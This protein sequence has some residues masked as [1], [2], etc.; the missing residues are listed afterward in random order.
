MGK[1]VVIEIQNSDFEQG[2]QVI[3][4]IGECG[5]NLGDAEG[6]LPDNPELFNLY[7]EWQKSYKSHQ[8]NFERHKLE[9]INKK[10][11][12]IS[13]FDVN[14]KSDK[15][16]QQL[17]QWLDSPDFGVIEKLFKQKLNESEQILVIVRTDKTELQ[18][19][20]W[21][22]WY[23][24]E[25]YTNADVALCP[26]VNNSSTRQWKLSNHPDKIR[27]LAAFGQETENALKI[28]T[29]TNYELLKKCLCDVKKTIDIV[30]IF[31]SDTENLGFRLREEKA[32]IF[33]YAGH[34][35]SKKN[36]KGGEIDGKNIRNLTK[37]FKEAVDKGLKLAIF[38]SCEGLGIANQLLKESHIPHV[39]VMREPIQDKVAHTFLKYFIQ[40][41]TE[42]DP[43]HLALKKARERLHDL[44]EEH[45][46]ASW[47]PVIF[48][49]STE[50]PSNWYNFQTTWIKHYLG[51]I[52]IGA[53]GLIIL[54]GMMGVMALRKQAPLDQIAKNNTVSING[55][56]Q[57]SAVIFAK[58]GKTYYVL[59]AKSIVNPKDKYKIV[60][61]DGN[62]H[63]AAIDTKINKKISGIDL[64]ILQFDSD[65]SYSI[66]RLGNSDTAR[67]GTAVFLS[68]W[69]EIDGSGEQS[70]H[71]IEGEIASRPKT[72]LN[73]YSLIYGSNSREGM[74]GGPLIDTH[75]CVIGIHALRETEA[76]RNF[77]SAQIGLVNNGFNQGISM[78]KILEK[79]S[80][81]DLEK[82]LGK[83]DKDC[84]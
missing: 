11:S 8:A 52:C 34:S 31:I 26:T 55:K 48:Q 7:K 25:H 47:L 41:F 15:L 39:V 32:D 73:G 10:D 13:S 40:K 44:E 61:V 70:Y 3:I 17:N 50:V 16:K 80:E 36:R 24:F 23:I 2:F 19:L 74:I 4:I 68:G 20:P 56:N 27:V 64:V 81:Q 57:G 1:L 33:Y 5:R 46:G 67:E 62:E 53:A 78:K 77:E 76:I 63:I 38:N 66:A 6:N 37:A 58:K 22:L 29:K 75:G 30:P 28:D 84:K 79:I 71:F 82:D 42:G 65:E 18:E 21:H 59:T 49:H 72:L 60:T 51:K 9:P 54:S 12:N 83:M 69:S 43:L 14:D 35:C 45:P